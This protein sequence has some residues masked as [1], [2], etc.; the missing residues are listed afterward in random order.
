MQAPSRVSPAE[1]QERPHLVWPF[2][3]FVSLWV[4]SAAPLGVFSQTFGMK[5]AWCF[6]IAFLQ[7][8]KG[9]LQF[10]V[11][12][13]MEICRA[14]FWRLPGALL[15]AWSRLQKPAETMHLHSDMADSVN[16]SDHI[17]RWVLIIQKSYVWTKE[18]ESKT[19]NWAASGEDRK[20]KKKKKE[21]ISPRKPSLLS[22]DLSGNH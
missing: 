12:K 17:C 19:S 20:K 4:L 14:V 13:Q 18:E 1:E 21:W 2:F 16:I 6:R 8:K 11:V 5:A 10:S 7:Q 15:S 22:I 9:H 3:P